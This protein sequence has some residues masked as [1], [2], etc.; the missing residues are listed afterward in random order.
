M[1]SFKRHKAI[2]RKILKVKR[3]RGCL[4]SGKFFCVVVFGFSSLRQFRIKIYHSASLFPNPGLH[5]VIA[6]HI[7]SH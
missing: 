2:L 3:G 6:I 4:Q 7:Q 5:G 1:D